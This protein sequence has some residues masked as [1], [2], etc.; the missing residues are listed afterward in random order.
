MW[1]RTITLHSNS[2]ISEFSLFVLFFQRV[3]FLSL[4]QFLSIAEG[5]GSILNV[6]HCVILLLFQLE[7]Q[8]ELGGEVDSW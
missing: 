7:G 8:K 6:N 1:K 5:T 4:E 3:A 2:G